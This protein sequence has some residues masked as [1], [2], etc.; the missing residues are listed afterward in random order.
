MSN[1]SEPTGSSRATACY[2]ALVFGIPAATLV[3]GAVTLWIAAAGADAIAPE[4][5]IK[6]GL[7]IE[8]PAGPAPAERP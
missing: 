7:A 2:V 8:R 1:R 4:A 5:H 3:A 6:S